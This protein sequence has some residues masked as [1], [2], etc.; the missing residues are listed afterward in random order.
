MNKLQILPFHGIRKQAQIRDYVLTD[1]T[2]IL[3]TAWRKYSKPINPFPNKPWFLCVWK[4]SRKRR[5]CLLQAISPF[6]SVFYLFEELAAIFMQFEIVICELFQFGRVE[7]LLFGKQL[8]AYYKGSPVRT[9][10]PSIQ[11]LTFVRL[12]MKFQINWWRSVGEEKE[13]IHLHAYT[14]PD[15]GEWG[16]CIGWIRVWCHF[17][18]QSHIMG[19]SDACAFPGF[20]TPVLTTFLSKVTD[21]FPHML[22]QRWGENAPDRKK[23]STRD[24]THDHQVMSPT[25]SPL[26][27]LGGARAF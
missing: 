21:Y 15:M 3:N 6:P 8:N 18:S 22:L 4:H 25:C 1:I 7:N 9:E 11:D 14:A 16:L 20:L 26:S 27:H 17:N 13:T 10:I 12:S 19:V 5:N 24:R 2:Q 23:A